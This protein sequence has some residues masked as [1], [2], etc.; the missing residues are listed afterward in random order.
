MTDPIPGTSASLQAVLDREVQ[1]LRAAGTDLQSVE[2]KQA[3]GGLPRTVLESVCALANADGGLLILGLTDGDFTPADIDAPKLAADLGSA[4][5]DGLEPA[6]R[7]EIDIAQ[8]DGRPVVVARIGPLDYRRRP[9]YLKS[10]GLEGGAFLRT[11]DGDRRL[12]SYEV[13]VMVSGRGQPD[14]DMVAV[15]RARLSDLSPRLTRGLIDRLRATRGPV[16]SESGDEEVLNMMGVLAEPSADSAVTLAGL[17]ALGRY[18]QQFFPQL[19]ATFVVL[20]TLD[21]APMADGT[22]FL[23]NRSLDGSIPAIV[24]AAEEA[25]FRNMRRRA[26]IVGVGREDVWD[27]P[28]E[29][30][31]EVVANALMHR[32]YHP[33]AHGSPTQISLFP[34]RLEVTSIGGLH[35]ANAGLSSVEDLAA[36]GV[37]ATRNLQLARLLEDVVTPRT[38]RPVCENRG[39][40]LRVAVD[41]LRRAGMAP[42]RLTDRVRVFRVVIDGST[43]TSTST[44]RGTGP[45]TGGAAEPDPSSL[46]PRERQIAE[47][48]SEGSLSSGRLAAEIGITRQ[49]VRSWLNRMAGRGLVRRTEPNRHS[50]FNRWELNPDP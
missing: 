30:V 27:Y 10:K 20:P 33:T 32:D 47:L 3:S 16:F 28:I 40:G 9:C 48:L 31:R 39:S 41:A 17:L 45:S 5:A 11:H 15:E 37:I 43:P 49:A 7:P 42:P 8:V 26:V 14:D 29:A 36:R 12:N 6:V 2:V 23:D 46:S 34:D 50:P 35:G 19:R 44:G 1:R 38:G 22:R 24:E 18:P 4:C 25:M 21:G 13:H